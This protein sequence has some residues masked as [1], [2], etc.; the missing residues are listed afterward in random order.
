LQPCYNH[1]FQIWR[2]TRF[3][4][5]H[6][7][8]ME[9]PTRVLAVHRLGTDNFWW[10]LDEKGKFLVDSMYRELIHLEMPV[11][12]RRKIWKIKK[13][14]K[15]IFCVICSSRTNHNQGKP[16][17]IQLAWELKVLPHSQ[18]IRLACVSRSLI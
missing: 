10:N 5:S 8:A 2:L 3:N 11:G 17:K 1:L 13:P 9:C 14:L 7:C 4:W 18:F 6:V 16:C 15:I 12:F